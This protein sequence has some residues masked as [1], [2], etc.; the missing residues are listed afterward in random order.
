MGVH[1]SFV[2][3]C[4]LSSKCSTAPCHWILLKPC[5]VYHWTLF[6]HCFISRKHVFASLLRVKCMIPP[7]TKRSQIL[8][9]GGC[10]L[11]G[12]SVPRKVKMS[13]VWNRC[14]S[15]QAH[16]VPVEMFS[17]RL[18]VTYFFATSFLQRI[19]VT[20]A[21]DLSWSFLL[22]PEPLA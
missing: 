19:K 16:Y 18:Q 14:T 15:F 3:P 10:S 22:P 1:D 17:V 20:P 7:T 5:C 4:P 11:W 12:L 21:A 6:T 2:W 13:Q 8:L 9:C